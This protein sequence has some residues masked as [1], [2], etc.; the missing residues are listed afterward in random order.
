MKY[1][2]QWELNQSGISGTNFILF[3]PAQ[4]ATFR[5]NLNFII[6]DLKGQNIDL[7]KFAEISV[8]QKQYITNSKILQSE[9]D[10]PKHKIVYTGSQGQL[11]LKWKQYYWVKNE[12]ACILTFT[13]DQLSFDKQVED[14]NSI[15]DS[16]KIK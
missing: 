4:S 10:G 15:M 11:N 16:F 5:D 3:A 7:N 14:V 1:P 6:Q 9:T 8:Q 13:A 12:K 2:G